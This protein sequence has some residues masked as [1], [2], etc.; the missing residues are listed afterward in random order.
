MESVMSSTI[1]NLTLIALF[2][3]LAA[4][5]GSD[6][7]ATAEAEEDLAEDIAED[8]GA[9]AE[10][11]ITDTASDVTTTLADVNGF[12]IVTETHNP[13]S[14]NFYGTEVIIT[15]FV[16]DHS[17]N[18]VEDGTVVTFVS[19]DHGLVEDQCVT[20]TGRCTVTWVSA[21][22]RSEPGSPNTP[23]INADHKITIMARTIGEDSFIDKNS[24]S[25]FDVGETFFTQSE[26]FL[27]ADDDGAY[28]SGV[29]DFDE[30]FDYNG[31]GEFDLDTEFT[32]F[33]GQSC[34]TAAI[35][36]GH[37]SGQLEVWDSVEMINSNGG[38]V[39]LTM[40]NCDGSA[41]PVTLDLAT[42]GC[43][44]IELR[45]VN[46]NIPPLGTKITTETD[47]GE[48]TIEPP[49]TIP[50]AFAEPGTGFVQTVL[51]RDDDLAENADPGFLSFEIESL[52]GVTT[53]Y[54]FAID[55]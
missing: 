51:L 8:T 1:K 42:N 33:R 23:N 39:S 19:D 10:D 34:S 40:T 14:D 36:A 27:D 3:A 11:I 13:R 44:E 5:G 7:I 18:P 2:S 37:C 22:D 49:A 25:L 54:Y 15:A 55:D 35:A 47:V 16:K 26:P 43:F 20:T 6:D 46:G 21:E 53:Y 28:D 4:C 24:N 48:L 45:D 30:F 52:S 31:N 17:N 9:S 12:S 38:S 50:N 41:L 29:N 32:T